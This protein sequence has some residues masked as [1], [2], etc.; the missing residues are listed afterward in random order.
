[1]NTADALLAAANEWD[2][3]SREWYYA[4]RYGPGG[5]TYAEG[6]EDGWGHAT[7]LLRA[8]IESELQT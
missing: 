4:N 8:L 5:V 3:Q 1:M 6:F 7:R 2:Q